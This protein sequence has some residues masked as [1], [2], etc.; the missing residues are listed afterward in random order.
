M[1]QYLIQVAKRDMNKKRLRTTGIR[2]KLN[3][4]VKYI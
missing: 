2:T 3:K 1:T 4:A